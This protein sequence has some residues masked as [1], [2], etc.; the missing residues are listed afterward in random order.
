MN[1]FR[2]VLRQLRENL[3]LAGI[4][5]LALIVGIGGSTGGGWARV[6][7]GV[8]SDEAD[9]WQAAVLEAQAEMA[10]LDPRSE[11]LTAAAEAFSARGE[12]EFPVYWD[13]WLQDTGS[14]FGSWLSAFTMPAAAQEATAQV[15][16]GA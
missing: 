8:L 7:A 5:V 16:G 3:G 11:A 4:V 12:R 14:D 1:D 10:S 9:G 13:W 2:C 15:L 6:R